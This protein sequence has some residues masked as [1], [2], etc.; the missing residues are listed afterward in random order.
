MEES[1]AE[2]MTKVSDRDPHEFIAQIEDERK[3]ADAAR[4][5]E[6]MTK[7]T[8]EAPRMWGNSIIGFGRYHYKYDSGHEG[9]T[10]LVGFSSRKAEFSIYLTGTYF[11]ETETKARALFDKLGNHRVGKACLYVKHLSDIDTVVLEQLI[12]LSVRGIKARYPS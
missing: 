9:D 5:T 4:L 3:R 11:P 6:M 10:C 2:S 12:D 8:G 1:M 7:A